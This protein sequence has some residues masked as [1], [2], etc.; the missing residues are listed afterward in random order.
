MKSDIVHRLGYVVFIHGSGVRLPVSEIIFSHFCWWK[1]VKVSSRMSNSLKLFESVFSGLLSSLSAATNQIFNDFDE[2]CSSNLFSES[3]LDNKLESILLVF[4]RNHQLYPK[5]ITTLT[6]FA[7][8]NP[9]SILK[10]LCF[11]FKNELNRKENNPQSIISIISLKFDNT[12]FYHF[13]FLKHL[14]L[15]IL[16]DIIYNIM[17]LF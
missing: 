8:S 7:D 10:Y 11:K 1:I 4:P 16:T 3:Q 6:A 12:D 13:Q 9:L 2:T 15:I 17:K 14:N 5:L